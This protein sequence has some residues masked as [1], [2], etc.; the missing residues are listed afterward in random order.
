MKKLI[1][2]ILFW[3][4][5]ALIIASLIIVLYSHISAS[6][7][8]EANSRTVSALNSLMPETHNG[9]FDDRTDTSMPTVELKKM[10]Y[11]GII[12]IPL[13][14]SK[15]PVAAKWSNREA[16]KTPCR[17]SGSVYDGS[18]IIGASE[19][20]FEWADIISIGEKITFTDMTGAVFSY[21]ISDIEVS[22]KADTDTLLSESFDLSIFIKDT[23]SNK[24][25]I[26]FCSSE[27]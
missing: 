6:K 21:N 20:Q 18:L 1:T 24:Y 27:N 12:E 23:L 15:L 22:D 17:Y 16:E 8:N 10:D 3:L 9:F 5:I 13:Y 4:G 14:N 11:I 19:T 7:A 25:T 2:K 26:I